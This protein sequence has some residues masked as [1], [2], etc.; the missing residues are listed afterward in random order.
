MNIKTWMLACG[1]VVCLL[2]QSA[3]AKDIAVCG[4]SDGYAYFPSVGL[5][6]DKNIQGTKDAISSGKFTLSI[7]GLDTFD[8]L[9]T[10]ATGA[11]RS[12]TQDGAKVL[13]IGQNKTSITVLI[14]YPML[15]EVYT[16]LQSKSGPEVM[17]TTNKYST[18]ILKAGAYR[19]ACKFVEIPAE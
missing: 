16:F 10:D 9:F 3:V 11:V 4:R 15:A 8:L 18:P 7:S 14:V 12:A 2:A 5:M 19:A 1:L 13:R 17:W 6:A